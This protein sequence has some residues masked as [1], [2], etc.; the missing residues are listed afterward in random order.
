MLKAPIPAD[1]IKRLKALYDYEVLDTEAEKV[2]DDLTALASE[3]CQTPISLIS[4][5]DPDRQ[6]FKSRVG[7]GALETSRDIAFCS[8]AI[9]Q[10]D[11]FEVPNALHDERFFDNPLVTGDPNIRFYAGTPLKSPS[12]ENIGTLC[13]INDEPQKLTDHQKNALELLGREVIAQLELRIKNKQ[14]EKSNRY[15]TEFLSN[16]SHEIRTPLNAIIGLSDLTLQH[17]STENLAPECIEYLEQINH[18]GNCLLG[19]INSVLDLSKIE[20]GKLEVELTTCDV[21]EL[22]LGTISMFRHKADEKQIALSYDIKPIPQVIIDDKKLSQVLINLISNAIKF[23]SAGK[24]IKIKVWSSNQSLCFEIEDQ[25]VG[26]SRQ[27]LKR[28]FNKYIQVGKNKSGQQGTGLG[29]SITKGL[30]DLLGGTIHIESEL[31]VGTSVNLVFPLVLSKE[32]KLRGKSEAII[33]LPDNLNVLMVEDNLVNQK[34][35]GALLTRLGVSFHI[36]GTGE[37][38]PELIEQNHY[39]IVL[40]DINLPG[41]SGLEVTRNLKEQRYKAPILALTADVFLSNQEKAIFDS[42][43]TKPIKYEQL[44]HEICLVLSP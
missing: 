29:L 44:E 31:G 13:V 8:H 20:A 40:M 23:T 41:I 27:D 42:F 18:S 36:A 5:I 30:V 14:L 21:E 38:V 17:A 39:D 34:V 37:E 19:I 1:E 10:D 28:L 12:G 43:V 2:F 7:L 22:V 24:H 6:W 35:I 15:K 9:L 26:I 11:V 4:L 32:E 25:G 33:Q 16:I 3:I